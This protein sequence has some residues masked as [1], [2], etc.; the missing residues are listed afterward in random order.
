MLKWKLASILND[1]LFRISQF[2]NCCSIDFVKAK[3]ESCLI[4]IN[5]FKNSWDIWGNNFV[6]TI[7]NLLNIFSASALVNG[8]KIVGTS[9]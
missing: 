4:L 9:K 5:T 7:F 6:L 2:V 8:N 1:P 3:L